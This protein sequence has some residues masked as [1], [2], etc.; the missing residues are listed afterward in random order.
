[1]P[2]S[3]TSE[4]TSPQNKALLSLEPLG[5]GPPQGSPQLPGYT[6]EYDYEEEDDPSAS[7]GSRH[8]R[9]ILAH[10]FTYEKDQAQGPLV[11]PAAS[12]DQPKSPSKRAT[13]LA[14]NYAPGEEKKV[15]ETAAEK[16]RVLTEK[17]THQL[18]TPGLDYVES[19][20]RKDEAKTG[21][22]PTTRRANE[23]MSTFG[24]AS[25]EAAVLV[26]K[27]KDAT[28]AGGKDKDAAGA[29]SSG[30]AAKSKSKSGKGSKK[31]NGKDD[32][33]DEGSSSDMDEYSE[34]HEG[35]RAVGD[36]AAASTPK[37]VKTTTKQKVIQDGKGITQNIEEKVEDLTPGGSGAITVSNTVNL[38]RIF[39][40]LIV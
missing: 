6:R 27:G 8:R 36:L 24:K 10:G 17:G 4:K 9:A 7:P 2:E 28:A 19:A 21:G 18:V 25:K 3:P 12:D 39:L 5:G 14:F 1:M 37:I 26:G 34:G 31:Q 22:S 29:G 11:A 33:S 40:H 30:K 13:G 20:R 35:I 32:S 15:A 23:P 38:V 16:K